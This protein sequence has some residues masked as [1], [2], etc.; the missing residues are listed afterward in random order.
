MMELLA[1]LLPGPTVASRGG[2][3]AIVVRPFPSFLQRRGR[4]EGSVRSSG[5]ASSAAPTSKAHGRASGVLRG[6][7]GNGS[8]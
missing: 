3:G 5:V 7:G 2:G 4:Y 1:G 8:R 6:G